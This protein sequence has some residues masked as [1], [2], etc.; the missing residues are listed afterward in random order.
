MASCEF[1]NRIKCVILIGGPSKGTRF[2]PLSLDIPK[3]LFPIAGLPMIQHHIEACAKLEN[4]SEIVIIGSYHF[5]EILDF[6]HE[7]KNLY[8]LTINYSQ[9]STPLG[10]AGGLNRFCGQKCDNTEYLF[11]MNGDV[12]ADFPL[13]DL[14]N[15][16]CEK[17]ALITIMA[18]ETTRQQ[19]SNY[20][21]MVLDK[22]N[23]VHHYVEKPSTFVSSLINCGVYVMQTNIF[24]EMYHLFRTDQEKQN[25][26]EHLNG[27]NNGA[28]CLSLEEDIFTKLVGTGRMFAL[29]VKNW[30]SQVK[31]AGAAIYANRH[32]LSLYRERKPDRL[33]SVIN[34]EDKI[35]G[36][37]Y[38][39]PTATVD[40][41]CVL[42]PNVSIGENAFIGRGV[43]IRESIVL[44]NAKILDH[45]II[46]NSIIGTYCFVG[47]W[48][49]V[50]G[51]PCDPNPNKPFAKME[52][53]PLFNDNGKLNPAITILSS[54]VN[55]AREKFVLNSV[56]LP[57]KKLTR[58][59]KNEIVL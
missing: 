28:A 37:V 7:M 42:G 25:V 41:T 44:N 35:I 5:S 56:V 39:H 40:P 29:P 43:R 51:T 8:S 14:L 52:N 1:K 10:T 36:D 47:E 54:N 18:T 23:E 21:C 59:Y 33:T 12:C 26:G 32:Y 57:H 31:T 55:L 15:F 58:N 22:H 16:H 53:P 2:R 6:I 9:E 50:E 27:N 4:L 46:L 19:S 11:V 49:R 13:Q 3:P 20:G 24:H 38:I 48:A 17:K 45:S 30:W 34:H